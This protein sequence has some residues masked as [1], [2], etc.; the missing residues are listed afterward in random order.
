MAIGTYT[1][2]QTAVTNWLARSDL[3]S[4]IPEFITLAEA[5]MNRRLRTLDQETKSTS[6]SITGEFVNVPTSFLAVR[7]FQTSA[8]G[9]RYSLNPSTNEQMVNDNPVSSGAPKEY[10]I[11]GGQFRFA[12]IP[13]ATYT[14]T[15]VYYISIPPLASNSTNWLLTAH[16]DVY[17][18]G[19][20]LQA[21]AHIQN[22]E[23]VP[24]WKQAFDG[25]IDAI[26]GSNNRNR[27]SG[28]SMATRAA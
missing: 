9:G 24:M 6:Y 21:A 19:A 26:Q 3:T 16:P 7:S 18:Y 13:D 1:E 10:S 11:V 8:N 15:L 2:L 5:E 4:R 17:L 20:L 22:D 28:P 14:A 12:P 23:R 25:A 27:W